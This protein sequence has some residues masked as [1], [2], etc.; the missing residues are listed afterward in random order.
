MRRKISNYFYVGHKY[1]E[2]VRKQIRSFILFTLGFTIAFTWREYTFEESK[3]LIKWITGTGGTG[4]FGAALF[5]TFVC[6]GLMLLASY[7]FK[8]ERN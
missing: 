8:N 4:A 6:V 3:R 5:I 2:E 1:R 7:Y